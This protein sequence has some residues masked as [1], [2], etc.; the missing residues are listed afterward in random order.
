MTDYIEIPMTFKSDE[1][2]SEQWYTYEQI[3]A[4]KENTKSYA[5]NMIYEMLDKSLDNFA[6]F[7]HSENSNI[8][9]QYTKTVKILRNLVQ[10]C[11]KIVTF[12]QEMTQNL[13]I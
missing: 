4:I 1:K 6:L 5:T 3:D 8:K 7:Y 12:V 10:K 9:P 13:N 2:D 11:A